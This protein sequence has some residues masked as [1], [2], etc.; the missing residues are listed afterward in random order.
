MVVIVWSIERRGEALR[1]SESLC[2]RGDKTPDKEE[3]GLEG[4]GK[5]MDFLSRMLL[6]KRLVR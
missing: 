5:I 4:A 6:I 2:S 1:R 3:Q